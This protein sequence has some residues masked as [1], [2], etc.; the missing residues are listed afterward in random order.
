MSNGDLIQRDRLWHP[1]ALT[2][3][4]K[5]SVARSPRHALLSLQNS[6]SELTG[7]TFGQNDI[8]EIDNDLILNYAKTG[9]PIGERIIVH[10]R[11]LDENARPVPNTL[12]EI[13]QANAGGRYRHKKDSYLAPIDPNFGGCGRTLTDDNGNY[14]FRTVKPGAYPWRNWVNNWRP[15]HIHFSVFGTAFAQR[16][17]TQ[18]YFEG[19]PLIAKCPI[20]QS[21]PEQ[22]AVDQLVAALDLNASL[23]LDSI[24]YKF[25]IVLR[26]RRSTF[27][28]NRPE[29]N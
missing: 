2:P 4:Y 28:E 21:I 13:W 1:P 11:V 24:A 26:G 12:V 23:P 3:D 19:D 29:G 22:R 5:T 17:I 8:A 18:M 16:L 10:G 15:A 25:D 9:D 20:V 6:D 14:V 27:F 7:P